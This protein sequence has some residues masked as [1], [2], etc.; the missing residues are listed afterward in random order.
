MI[1]TKTLR[2]RLE[3]HNSEVAG[4][5]CIPLLP[6]AQQYR[7]LRDEATHLSPKPRVKHICV[8]MK[9][10]PS[11]STMPSPPS[12]VHLQFTQTTRHLVSGLTMD[13]LGGH[14]M[15]LQILEAQERMTMNQ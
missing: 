10:Q 6:T 1:D 4:K 3:D 9:L 7:R 5:V 14:R 13:H 12:K 11:S 15:S 8:S 2:T